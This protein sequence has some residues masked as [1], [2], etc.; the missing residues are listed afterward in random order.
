MLRAWVA[1]GMVDM[2]AE[3]RRRSVKREA[4]ISTDRSPYEKRRKL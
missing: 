3:T 1:V 2:V 4:A